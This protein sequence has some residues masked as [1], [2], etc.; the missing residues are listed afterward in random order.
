MAGPHK[1]PKPSQTQ[2]SQAGKRMR[3]APWMKYQVFVEA[4]TGSRPR[5]RR[6]ETSTQVEVAYTRAL[7]V[8]GKAHL[9][10]DDAFL[11]ERAG[12][13][14]RRLPGTARCRTT[15]RG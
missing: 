7:R 11:A 5:A 3:L 10:E 6:Q 14:P 15:G 4:L 12:A 8:L 1:D 2:A 9:L 13:R